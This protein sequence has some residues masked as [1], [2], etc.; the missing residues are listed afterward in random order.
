[1]AKYDKVIKNEVF[2]LGEGR[3][4]L[5]KLLADGKK[6]DFE[7]C[8]F[9]SVNLDDLSF[10]GSLF[11][12]CVFLDVISNMGVF[13]ETIFDNCYL[14]DSDFVGADFQDAKFMSCDLYDSVFPN[15]M[16]NQ[17]DSGCVAH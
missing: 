8:V 2:L 15:L 10:K 11:S 3:E 1:M 16:K 6:Y 9:H 17:M 5:E 7:N 13:V 4:E 14:A 12:S